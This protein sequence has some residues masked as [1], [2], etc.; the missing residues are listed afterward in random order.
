MT[1]VDGEPITNGFASID[2]ATRRLTPNVA[3][4]AINALRPNLHLS[5][6]VLATNGRVW[7]AG[8]QHSLQVLD[9]QTLEL[10]TFY[11]SKHQ[12]DFQALLLVGDT[13][14]AG[15]HCNPRTTL[16]RSEGVLWWGSRPP[17][18]VNAPILE[19]T[20]N[21]WVNAFDA[22]TG[23]RD[24]S[25]VPDIESG[26]AGIWALEDT[27]DGCLW[28]GGQITATAGTEQF[29]MTRLCEPD[30]P[31][32]LDAERPSTPGR[33]QD[34]GAGPNEVALSWRPSTDN[35]AVTGYRLYDADTG[36]VR[37]VT[38]TPGGTFANVQAGAHRFYVKAFD[39]AGNESWRSGTRSVSVAGVDDHERPSV[40]G[41]P[42]VAALTPT[43]ATLRWFASSDNVAVAGYRIYNLAT[44][45]VI[46]GTAGPGA[47]LTGLDRGELRL[48]V[49]S[50][51]AAGNVSWR[52]GITTLT[53]G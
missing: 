8:N 50:Y 20:A 51:D 14:Y 2:L 52:S 1:A 34:Q 18:V 48:Y 26:G 53:I 36:K 5:N 32:A 7:V 22:E 33:P 12:G 35:V 46:T 37:F 38:A 29:A 39:A 6:D 13:I 31:V 45:R 40:P 4:L 24:N 30:Q 15:C 16:A 42:R 23:V 28:I 49:R 17:G 19:S 9:E 43:S 10:E 41:Q 27:V 21:S 3:N 44:G 25:F 11:L 47:T